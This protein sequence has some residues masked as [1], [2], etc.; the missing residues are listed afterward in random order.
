MI[1]EFHQLPLFGKPTFERAVLRAPF[2]IAGKFPNEACFIYFVKADSKLYTPTEQVHSEAGQSVVMQCGQ[3][4][5]EYLEGHEDD[6][7]EAIA[8]HLYP[9]VLKMLYD[10]ELP[11]FLDDV[12][13]VKPIRFR[14]YEASELMANY[15]ASLQFYFANPA[16]VT[17]EL[18][19]LKLKEL[20]ILLARTDKAETIRQLFAG[21][22]NRQ[23]A[24]FREVIE[25][26]LY[27]NLHLEE[28]ATLTHLSLSSFKRE[29]KRQYACPPARYIRQRRLERAAQLLRTTDLRVSDVAF[30]CGFNDLAHFSKTFLK[31]YGKPPSKMRGD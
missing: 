25:A 4:L 31:A 6:E 18:L 26:N 22:F 5:N 27:Q 12:A 28:L 3:Y 7:C 8:V 24:D 14:Q 19:K 2:R 30:D 29:F 15:I 20:V 11:D 9:E 21:L 13:R 17:D 1:Q 10:K 23:R 16:L